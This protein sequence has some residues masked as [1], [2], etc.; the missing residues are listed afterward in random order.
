M[1]A[2]LGR[3][4]AAFRSGGPPATVLLALA[5]AL[6][7][8]STSAQAQGDAGPLPAAF[9]KA[10]SLV[11]DFHSSH[12]KPSEPPP[13]A[14]PQAPSSSE[15]QSNS[16]A[17]ESPGPRAEP[18]HFHRD[19]EDD[20]AAAAAAARAAEAEAQA[21]IEAQRKAREA[22]HRRGLANRDAGLKEIARKEWDAAVMH[23]TSALQDLPGDAD[24][25]AKLAEAQRGLAERNERRRRN[26]AAFDP[27][28][29]TRPSGRSFSSPT[30]RAAERPNP[31][32]PFG[33]SRMPLPRDRR[34]FAPRV[35]ERESTSAFWG[36]AVTEEERKSRTMVGPAASVPL[37]DASVVDLREAQ[38][39]VIDPQRVKGSPIVGVQHPQPATA[40]QSGSAVPRT[41]RE[42]E[43]A[44]HGVREA[45]TRLSKSEA[46]DAQSRGEWEAQ[47]LQ[48]SG[49]AL[50]LAGNMVIDGLL[51]SASKSL[52]E[53]ANQADAEIHRALDQIV[54]ESPGP[55]KERLQQAI[56]LL[57]Q[58][59]AEIRETQGVLLA[60]AEQSNH[61]R[62]TAD[63]AASSAGDL[64]K[65]VEGVQRL[66][67]LSLKEPAVQ[68]A[69]HISS[70]VGERAVAG[71][72]WG[73]Q[74]IDSWYAVAQQAIS[75]KRL[76]ELN[77]N[78]ESR[79][80]AVAVLKRRMES[81][82]QQRK[83]RD[84]N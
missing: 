36:R 26:H 72:K 77:A 13:A 17:S 34:A 27:F 2:S 58:Q 23:F 80:Q 69:L 84:S 53:Q 78:A 64:E 41:S 79:L 51:E 50:K 70:E 71:L 62:S 76:N 20:A 10:E 14:S 63:W 31:F 54:N 81:L 65:S 35:P 1:T 37:W 61:L 18:S 39:L 73:K 5:G 42:I 28:D 43:S 75:V 60:R 82:E 3:P 55:R 57:D 8:P 24:V 40:S 7:I 38:T 33:D 66:L 22:A 30:P 48:A 11:K 21:R 68:R 16:A 6:A 59:R 47:S 67:E 4:S 83:R 29:A 25:L 52:K 56:K 19:V 12:E 45:L 46:L 49:D 74:D 44:I 9:K 32:D 15:S